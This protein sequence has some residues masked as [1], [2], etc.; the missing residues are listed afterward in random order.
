MS[1][2]LGVSTKLQLISAFLECEFTTIRNRKT[3]QCITGYVMGV[4]IDTDKNDQNLNNMA[5]GFV[6]LEYFLVD[7]YDRDNKVLLEDVPV[8]FT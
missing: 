8:C 4:K 5:Q 2:T 1:T 3:R 6:N 7:F